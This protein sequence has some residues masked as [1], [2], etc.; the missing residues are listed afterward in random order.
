MTK[1]LLH[2]TNQNGLQIRPQ[3]VYLLVPT[4]WLNSVKLKGVSSRTNVMFTQ[5]NSYFVKN[6][7]IILFFLFFLLILLAI[8]KCSSV[9]TIS[10]KHCEC[11]FTHLFVYVRHI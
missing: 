1:F 4:L 6:K 10:V 8:N 11:A 9:V 2:Q 5:H 3:E 7:I